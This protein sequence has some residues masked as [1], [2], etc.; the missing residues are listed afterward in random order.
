MIATADASAYVFYSSG[1]RATVDSPD[2]VTKD[3]LDDFVEALKGDDLEEEYEESTGRT[4]DLVS[5]SF[6]VLANA[7]EEY[8]Q[9]Y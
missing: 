2:T 7:R 3:E 6:G 8:G 9:F 1:D 5:V 4:Q